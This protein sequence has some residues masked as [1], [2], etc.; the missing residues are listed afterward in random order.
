[1]S[2]KEIIENAEQLV[3][4]RDIREQFHIDDSVGQERR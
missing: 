3:N 2:C 1:M 4:L